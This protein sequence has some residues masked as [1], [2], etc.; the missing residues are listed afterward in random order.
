M[1]PTKFEHT[2]SSDSHRS[3]KMCTVWAGAVARRP[4]LRPD[5][6]YLFDSPEF[7]MLRMS[8]LL[9]VVGGGMK[10]TCGTRCKTT[11]RNAPRLPLRAPGDEVVPGYLIECPSLE[12][13]EGTTV[14]R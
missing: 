6:C 14:L 2:N 8:L 11:A 7:S 12:L 13:F 10:L 4:M 1:A 3:V 9:L 5:D